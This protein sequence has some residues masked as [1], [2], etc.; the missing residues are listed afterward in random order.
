LSVSDRFI[1]NPVLTT[2]CSLVILLIGGVA[3]PLLPLEKLPQLAPT[4]IQVTATNIGADARTTFD[5]TTRALEKEIN[6][7]EDMKYISSNTSS[8]GISNINVFF[9]V[10]VDRNIAQVNVQNRVA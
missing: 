9:P 5:T 8:D 1:R 3:I 6:G 2:V 10:D 7:V 4:Q